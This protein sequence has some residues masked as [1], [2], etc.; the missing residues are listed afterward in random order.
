MVESGVPATAG[1]ELRRGWGLIAAVVL[2]SAIGPTVLV[3]YTAGIFMPAL[4]AEFG[5]TRGMTSL[6][7]T[8][9][10]ATTALLAP[11]AGTLADR[12]GVRA[13]LPVSLLAGAACFTA[14]SFIENS[15]AFYLGV[16]LLLGLIGSGAS[17]LIMS[18]PVSSAM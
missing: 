6:G 18:R 3:P 14:L 5:W 15:Y 8:L 4:Q 10:L 17:T 1:A 2:G 13:M 9:F 11:F 12:H 7:V 16:L